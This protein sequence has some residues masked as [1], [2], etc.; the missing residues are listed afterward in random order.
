MNKV[1]FLL[2]FASHLCHGQF[3]SLDQIKEA[4][5]DTFHW[6][7]FLLTDGLPYIIGFILLFNVV[8]WFNKKL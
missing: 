5:S 2:F 4:P 1:Y 6:W 7:K 8:K 3:R